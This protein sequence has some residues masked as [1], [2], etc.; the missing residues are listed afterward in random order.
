[1]GISKLVS[2]EYL[3]LSFTGT[4][5]LPTELK[6]LEKLKCLSLEYLGDRI[7]IPRGFIPGLSKLKTLRMICSFPFAEEAVED[8]S[9]ECLAEELQCLNHLNALT[10]SVTSAFALNRFL[11]AELLHSCTEQIGLHSFM[12][13][14]Q[15]NILSLANIKSLLWMRLRDWESLEEVKTE[16]EGE[17]RMIKA[18]KSQISSIATQKWFQSLQNVSI[19]DCSNLKDITW[20]TLTPNLGY[21]HVAKWKK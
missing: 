4:R 6:A 18:P 21:F 1:M 7:T 12:D 20:L 8:K 15:L 2:L 5:Q 3:D 11:S 10:V 14:K 17:G 13:S 19:V 16:W 9:T